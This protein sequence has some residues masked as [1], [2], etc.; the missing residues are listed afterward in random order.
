MQLQLRSEALH[1]EDAVAQIRRHAEVCFRCP[2]LQQR[3]LRG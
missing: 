3:V 1:F 2:P